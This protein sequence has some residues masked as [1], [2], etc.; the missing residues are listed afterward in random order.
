MHRIE[1]LEKRLEGLESLVSTMC[2]LSDSRSVSELIDDA[3]VM[4]IYSIAQDLAVEAG[5][6]VENFLKHY[7]IRFR[8]WHD[9]YLRQAE[10]I[11]P[12]RAAELDPRTFEQAAVS[13]TYPPL[14]DPP[15]PNTP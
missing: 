12:Q 2:D 13:A 4:A 7:E 11:S 15:Q 9:Y 6:S 5:I 8:W 14:F 10:D 1:A 3:K